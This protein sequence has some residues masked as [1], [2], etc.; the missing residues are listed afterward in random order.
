MK[1]NCNFQNLEMG[2]PLWAFAKK[3]PLVM[4]LF[5]ICL[6]CSI[7]MVQA[8]ESYAQ[9]ARIS[10]KVE[11]ETVADVLKEIEEASEFDFFYN[12]TQIDLNRRVSVSAQNS[13]IFTV[14]DEVFAGTKVRYTVLDKKIILS[15]ELVDEQQQQQPGNVVKG[16]V[17]DAAGEPVIGATV[18]EVGTNNGI[19]TDIDGNFS[20]AVQPGASLEIS[21]VGYK[22]ETVKAV[23]GKSLAVTLNE[24]NELLDEVVV[25]GYGVQRKTNLSGAVSNVSS[26][27]ID[28]K[29]VTN[30]I[31]ALQGE[32]PGMI[33][34]RSSGQPGV[35]DFNLNVRGASSTN[36]GNSPLVLIDGIQGDIN[37]VNPNDIENIS[38]LKD[39]AA[40]IYGARAA[41]GVIL[42][43]TKKGKNGK[44]KITYS[45]NVA[46]THATGMMKAPSAYQLA[47]MDNE[48]NIHNGAIPLYDDEMLQRILANDPNPIDHPTQPGWKLFF[49]NTNWMDEVLETG[50]QHKH[51]IAVSG[52]GE[53]N[54]Y[55]LS[56]GYSKQYG[57]VRYAADDDTRY[58]LRMNYDYRFNDW[59]KLETKVTL[60]NQKRE[61]GN[62]G[63]VINEAILDMPNFPVYNP[64]H[65]F[66]SQG[67]WSNSVA[68]A[69][70]SETCT[71]NTR[72]MYGNFKL[73]ANITNELI[74]NAQ[75]GISY[76]NRN[77]EVI[78][79]AIPLYT[80]DGNI[81]YY[82][83]AGSPEE[84]A[85]DRSTEET[86]YQNYT[87][88][89]NY[90]H[91]FNQSHHLDAMIGMAYETEEIRGFLARRDNFTTDGLWEL[92]LGGTGN[93]RSS[94][95]GQHWATA[96]AFARFG[97]SY[98]NKYILETN[99]RY[100]GS[101]RFAPGNRWRMFPGISASW[102]LSQEEWLK[103]L[104]VF[105]EL[106]LR[107]S[108]G[109][110]G[111][112]E[113][114]RLYDYIQLLKYGDWTYP[115]GD[116]SQAQSIGLDVLAGTDRTWEI[117]ENINVGIDASFL[118]SRLGI[119]FD[120]FVK[121]NNNMLIPVTYPSI[122]GA[123]PPSVNAGKLRTNGFELTLNW[124]DKVGE[125]DYSIQLQLSDAK[126][127][128]V[129]YGGA[130]TYQLGLNHTREGYPIDSYFAYVYDGVIRTEEELAEYKKLGGVPSNIGIG[131]AK[132]K[133]LNNDGKIS[134]Y[135]DDG[136][137]GDAKFVGTTSPRYT[138]GLTLG[139]KWKNFDISVF[140]QGVG[141]RTLFREGDFAMPWSEWWRYP[142]E[143]YYGKTWNEDRLDA[144]YPRLT[145]GEIRKWNYQASTLQKINAAYVRLKN[146]QI[147][148]TLP[149]T[150]LHKIGLERA[151]IYVSGQ[152][153][154]EIHGVEGGWDP[155]SS[156]VGNNY[157]FQRYYSFGIDLTF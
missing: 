61:D 95:N 40:S 69:K 29:P 59:L 6:F 116:G 103:N 18:K 121:L 137:D 89:M 85:V 140:F 27:V 43:T 17:I 114:I 132:F 104:K 90:S 136:S 147:G 93:M 112:Q 72:E 1:N 53:N 16:K 46:L 135:G 84:T 83:N 124:N 81:N 144:Y 52:G 110:T 125:V 107:A 31:S 128:L 41:G 33:I 76:K 57:V 13:N 10:L 151:R 138:F 99:L 82:T 111:N 127:K 73:V 14:L 91:T 63:W 145:H 19:V 105:D 117:L 80:W 54:N 62:A 118:D 98:K 3:I 88:Y 5:I 77:D 30:V 122:L 102:R 119:S 143:F 66:F 49:T 96:S 64:E 155:E 9:N 113:G 154:F 23:A 78:A 75:A 25:I 58:N 21:F 141:K 108:Y 39:A 44:P 142:P 74:L 60:N 100:D 156:T 51:N 42:I 20:L 36:G 129:D 15:T 115:F 94:G 56:A 12:N 79:N 109:Q 47:V 149:D 71:Y 8:V 35:E 123:T 67:G 65:Q 4:K 130:D 2:R 86:I 150:F 106:K 55:Y 87:A 34:Q 134:T 32:I 153:L 28:S 50:I 126:N 101:S 133:D 11:E 48:A 131:D 22:T 146:L 157:P 97:Y 148:Y 139:A 38:V 24:D 37:M 152:D 120:Y 68:L 45:G 92:D 70:E 7:G 26:K